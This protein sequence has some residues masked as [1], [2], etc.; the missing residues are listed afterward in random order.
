MKISIILIYLIFTGFISFNNYIITEKDC[1]S[2]YKYQ[3][4][5]YN[6]S[7]HD[8][9]SI[10]PVEK[11]N[12]KLNHHN[13]PKSVSAYKIDNTSINKLL[14]F[15]AHNISFYKHKIICKCINLYNMDMFLPIFT[16]SDK[17]IQ[18]E[19]LII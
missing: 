16:Q 4:L 11:Q 8:F 17:T 12:H 5:R 1:Q 13:Y 7:N 2:N 19:F 10:L 9:F 3:N 18:S 15:P 14:A 6:G